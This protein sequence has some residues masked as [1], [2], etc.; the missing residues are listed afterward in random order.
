MPEDRNLLYSW[1]GVR[2]VA[3]PFTHH[4]HNT[5]GTFSSATHRPASPAD[6]AMA[7]SAAS[8]EILDHLAANGYTELELHNTALTLNYTEAQLAEYAR[9][10]TS[11]DMTTEEVYYGTR[12]AAAMAE[13]VIMHKA[14]VNEPSI[15]KAT[16]QQLREYESFY[17]DVLTEIWEEIRALEDTIQT[18]DFSGSPKWCV[19]EA[20]FRRIAG[21]LWQT[22]ERLG[23]NIF[24]HL[25]MSANA[26]D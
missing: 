20:K 14:T 25:K 1:N 4:H 19:L 8:T 11:G 9:G 16:P 26:T 15:L 24:G 5:L 6:V 21:F 7:L 17:P 22:R 10:E 18:G 3:N 12:L 2:S 23:L 13:Q